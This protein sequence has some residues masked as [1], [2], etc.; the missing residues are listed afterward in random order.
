MVDRDAR[1][2]RTAFHEMGLSAR[3]SHL[4]MNK[5]TWLDSLVDK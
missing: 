1:I 2:I 3:R 5:H 4:V